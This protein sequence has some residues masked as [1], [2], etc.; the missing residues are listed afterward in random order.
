M[1]QIPDGMDGMHGVGADKDD[2]PLLTVE[3]IVVNM[4]AGRALINIIDFKFIVPMKEDIR[5]PMLDMGMPIFEGQEVIVIVNLMLEKLICQML[6]HKGLL[7][8]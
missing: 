7:I 4:V 8:R 3:I 1:L 2:V 6:F 5:N